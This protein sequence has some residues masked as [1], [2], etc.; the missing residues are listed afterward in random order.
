[1]FSELSGHSVR[2][3]P[4]IRF[5]PRTFE[6]R[7]P[8]V[9]PSG[10]W[11]LSLAKRL[12]TVSSPYLIIW[13]YKGVVP[14]FARGSAGDTMAHPDFGTSVNPI[15]TGGSQ[16]ADYAHQIILAPPDFQ[17]FLRP[18]HWYQLNIQLLIQSLA[19]MGL[20]KSKIFF[21]STEVRVCLHNAICRRFSRFP[22]KSCTWRRKHFWL[23]SSFLIS[24]SDCLNPGGFSGDVS[25]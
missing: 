8:S 17:T 25:F 16:G 4:V 12:S 21:L 13:S 2:V 6:L 19:C 3:L 23:V 11:L 1:M 20:F 10:L 15:S 18:C 22:G 14:G 9:P 5:E 7:V 24:Q